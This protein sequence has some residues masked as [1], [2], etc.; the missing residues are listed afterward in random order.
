MA[1]HTKWH[2]VYRAFYEQRSLLAGA[3]PLTIPA[4]G[5]AP[6]DFPDA[7]ARR[8]LGAV[9]AYLLGVPNIENAPFNRLLSL[10]QSGYGDQPFWRGLILD[11]LDCVLRDKRDELR[12][13]GAA[14]RVRIAESLARVRAADREQKMLVDAFAGRIA[15]QHFPINAKKLVRNY[16]RMAR[17]HPDEAWAVLTANPGQFSPIQTRDKSGAVVL[18]PEQAVD[19]N[20]KIA[21]FVKKMRL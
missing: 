15:E 10:V 6:A 19:A 16:F 21:G 7:Q 2:G 14:A 13:E 3:P 1:T 18:T 20:K 11:Y 8:E 12:R 17:A 5:V 4:D 9:A